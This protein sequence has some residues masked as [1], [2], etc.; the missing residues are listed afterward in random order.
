MLASYLVFPDSTMRR[1]SCTMPLARTSNG[2]VRD[3]TLRYEFCSSR[4]GTT[5]TWCC[6]QPPPSKRHHSHP[7]LSD[8]QVQPIPRVDTEQGYTAE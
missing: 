2:V 3:S 5:T 8:S 6:G 1:V 7:D 4:I